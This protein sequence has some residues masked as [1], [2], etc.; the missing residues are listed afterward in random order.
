MNKDLLRKIDLGQPF[1]SFWVI[2]SVAQS[3]PTLWVILT[4]Q[5]AIEL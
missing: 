1:W 3:C 2:S 4:W 5:L